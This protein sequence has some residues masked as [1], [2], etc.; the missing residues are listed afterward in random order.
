MIFFALRVLRLDFYGHNNNNYNQ[1]EVLKYQVNIFNFIRSG[2][3]QRGYWTYSFRFYFYH[4]F[5]R[6]T[7]FIYHSLNGNKNWKS[8]IRM[9]IHW[10]IFI[11]ELMMV[12]SKYKKELDKNIRMPFQKGNFCKFE[13]MLGEP[14]RSIFSNNDFEFRFQLS[15][16]S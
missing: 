5:S 6:F 1:I 12:R 14:W 16:Q 13:S 2:K 3:F 9:E 7:F 10:I 8:S 11:I 4:H 15:I